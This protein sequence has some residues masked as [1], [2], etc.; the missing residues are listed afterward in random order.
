MVVVSGASGQTGS[1]AALK[2]LERG[3]KVRAVGRSEEKLQFLKDKGA[4]LAIGD[5]HD[6]AFLTKAF[7][8][9]Q[10]AYVLIPPKVDAADPRAY[11]NETGDVIAQAIRDSGI[12]KIVFLSSLGAD[13]ESGTGPVLG[14]HDVEKKLHSI[15]SI[16]MVIL[17]PGYFMENILWNIPVIKNQNINGNPIDPDTK[18]W[19]IAAQ[20][21]GNRAAELL[22]DLSFSGHSIEDLFGQVIS[23]K[24]ATALIGKKIGKEDL[25]FVRFPDDAALEALKGL[26]LSQKTAEAFVELSHGLEQG[27]VRP[28]QTDKNKP[29]APTTYDAFVSDVF[30]P[31]YQ[32]S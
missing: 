11:Y 17:R 28:T 15:D 2:L 12:K 30:V 32:A 18:I 27:I 31:A 3:A 4:E 8:D 6:V 19:M 9:A 24:E 25:P 13:Q 21:I 14:L 5:Q 22:A 1:R 10:G 29:N 16:D 20:D 26:G 7:R 23:Y